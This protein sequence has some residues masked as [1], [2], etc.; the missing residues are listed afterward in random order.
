MKPSP[1]VRGQRVFLRG[2]PGQ[3]V[4]VGFGQ[5]T[6]ELDDGR[7]ELVPGDQV[8]LAESAE[9]VRRRQEDMDST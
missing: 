1:L 2:M 7:I 6:V 3:V 8:V 9:S 4:D 5:A